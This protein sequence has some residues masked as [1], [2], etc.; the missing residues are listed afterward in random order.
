MKLTYK[1]WPIYM[2]IFLS[3]LKFLIFGYFNLLTPN[4][5]DPIGFNYAANFV[6]VYA[7]K[8]LI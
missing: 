1:S 3:N 4:E 5:N 7:E 8:N 2:Q 6:Y